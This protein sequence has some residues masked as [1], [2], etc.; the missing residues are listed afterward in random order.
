MVMMLMAMGR[1]MVMEPLRSEIERMVLTAI[2]VQL[3]LSLNLSD[4]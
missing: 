1:R 2:T 4:I 3:C